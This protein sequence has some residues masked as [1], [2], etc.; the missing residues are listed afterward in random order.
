MKPIA[1]S[2]RS[3]WLNLVCFLIAGLCLLCLALL[4]GCASTP[5]LRSP[6][7][8]VPR[9]QAMPLALATATA[10]GGTV[11]EITGASMLPTL[12]SNVLAV[13]EPAPF[14]TLRAGDLVLYRNRAGTL[15]AHRLHQYIPGD[16]AW[17]A[18]GDNNAHADTQTVSATNYAG[19]VWV[20]FYLQN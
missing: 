17:F 8:A 19:R 12:G 1:R 16:A 6:A 14:A 10:V 3:H 20:V 7:S 2:V 18:L 13:C 9:E 4:S 15:I 5:L 11:H